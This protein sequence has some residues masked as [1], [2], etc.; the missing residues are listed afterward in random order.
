MLTKRVETVS[1]SVLQLLRSGAVHYTRSVGS[2]YAVCADCSQAAEGVTPEAAIR[3][4]QHTHA[5]SSPASASL[6]E[7]LRYAA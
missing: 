4:I 3:S 7:G 1:E 6:D 5:C 2:A